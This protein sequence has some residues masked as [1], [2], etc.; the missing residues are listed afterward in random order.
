MARLAR[1]EIFAPSE[2]VALHLIGNTVRSCYLMRGDERSGNAATKPFE[3]SIKGMHQ[4]GRRD[5][6][7]LPKELRPLKPYPS[8]QALPV[9]LSLTQTKLNLLQ[10]TRLTLWLRNPPS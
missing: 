7:H 5:A 10:P 3:F 8:P 4:R 1:A 2:I 9:P 6:A